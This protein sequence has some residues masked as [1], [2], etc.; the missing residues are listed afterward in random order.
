RL[1]AVELQHGNLVQTSQRIL[2]GLRDVRPLEVRNANVAH[3]LLEDL[4]A[5]A[6]LIGVLDR[7]GAH[8]V[9]DVVVAA[10]EPEAR[11]LAA[12]LEGAVRLYPFTVALTLHAHDNIR[13]N[14]VVALIAV[15]GHDSGAAGVIDG[16]A[17]HQTVVT[18]VNRER[19]LD[20]AP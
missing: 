4:E 15:F 14:D 8:V 2:T 18:V 20:A 16:V 9:P 11:P 19:P 1:V 12:R 10:V 13:F 17:L 6:G 3:F 7:V 5:V